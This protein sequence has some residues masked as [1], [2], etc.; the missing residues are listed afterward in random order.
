MRTST[1]ARIT[2]GF[3]FIILT[4]TALSSAASGQSSNVAPP[5]GIDPGYYYKVNGRYP[6]VFAEEGHIFSVIIEPFM[7]NAASPQ[8][9]SELIRVTDLSNNLVGTSFTPWQSQSWN[10]G[11]IKMAVSYQQRENDWMMDIV[12]SKSRRRVSFSILDLE[13]WQIDD[14]RIDTYCGTR[15]STRTAPVKFASGDVGAAILFWVPGAAEDELL[16]REYV[17]ALGPNVARNLINPAY[18][19][20]TEDSPGHQLNAWKRLGNTKCGLG[21]DSASR[22]FRARPG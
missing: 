11:H 15:Y 5:A 13:N 21:W 22:L 1:Y 17:T 8:P 3:V 10:D 20:V 6:A 19:F 18:V 9:R 16:S 2:I 14:T 4:F 7:D 12:F